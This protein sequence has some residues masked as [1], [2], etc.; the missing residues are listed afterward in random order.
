MAAPTAAPPPITPTA[1][2]ASLTLAMPLFVA[3]PL[4]ALPIPPMLRILLKPSANAATPRAAMPIILTMAL[5]P[6]ATAIAPMTT[7]SALN[8]V[9][10]LGIFSMRSATV[11]TIG[12]KASKNAKR[13][14]AK[15]S[16]QASFNL[17]ARCIDSASLT[18]SA[19]PA[20][21]LSMKA[22]SMVTPRNALPNSSDC[23]AALAAPLSIAAKPSR[24]FA[25]MSNSLRLRRSSR[26]T[27]TD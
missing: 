14:L 19:S 6:E 1:V 7:A 23:K 8:K 24:L 27:P 20:R 21:S 13:I 22:P 9:I 16:S 3:G 10:R 2:A 26:V 17:A 15:L 12:L 4:I 5:K 18:V 25:K 11:L